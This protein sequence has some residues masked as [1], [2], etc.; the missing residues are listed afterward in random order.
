MNRPVH[1]EIL[2]E[3]PEAISEFYRDVFGWDVQVWDG[4]QGYWVLST[5]EGTTGINGAVTGRH[6]NQAVINT[7]DV[8]ALDE[9]ISKVEDAGGKL[10]FGPHDV[11]EVGRHAYLADPEGILFGLLERV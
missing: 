4:P 6:F 3:N 1:F 7:I 2:S 9:M 5:G 11:P 8:A 10:V